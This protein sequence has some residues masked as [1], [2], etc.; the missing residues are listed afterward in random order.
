MLNTF[1]AACTRRTETDEFQHSVVLS[2]NIK[3]EQSLVTEVHRW[4]SVFLFHKM[5][6]RR[7][8]FP[9]YFEDRSRCQDANVHHIEAT[10]LADRLWQDC[11]PDWN[12]RLIYRIIHS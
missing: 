3:M 11:R 12:I 10:V 7:A 2:L 8:V 4:L 6:E 9:E 1:H 5:S